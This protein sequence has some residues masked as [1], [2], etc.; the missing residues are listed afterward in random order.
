MSFLCSSRF[1]AQ[2]SLLVS[3]VLGAFLVLGELVVQGKAIELLHRG[4]WA[5]GVGIIRSQN[6]NSPAPGESLTSFSCQGN[7][8]LLQILKEHVPWAQPW[9]VAAALGGGISSRPATVLHLPTYLVATPPRPVRVPSPDPVIL[10]FKHVQN[11]LTLLSSLS[12]L[13]IQPMSSSSW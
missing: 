2:N 9:P 5:G 13:K 6:I 11:L 8:F 1:L 12:P 10:S 4:A 3:C 7:Q